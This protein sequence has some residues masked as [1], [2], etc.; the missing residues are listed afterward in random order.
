[1]GQNI[2]TTESFLHHISG[3]TGARGPLRFTL[4]TT[5]LQVSGKPYTHTRKPPY[6]AHDQVIFLR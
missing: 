1:M 4:P 2:T 5:S 3:P 6:M